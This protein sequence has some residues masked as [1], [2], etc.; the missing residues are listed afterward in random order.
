MNSPVS[1]LPPITFCVPFETESCIAF[2]TTGCC[3]LQYFSCGWVPIKRWVFILFVQCCIKR[4]WIFQLSFSA[5]W[6]V[7]CGKW[8]EIHCLSIQWVVNFHFLNWTCVI[9]MSSPLSCFL[10]ILFLTSAWC[11]S[12]CIVL[13]ITW[14][15]GPAFSVYV[16][17][18]WDSG[19]SHSFNPSS[20]HTV[21]SFCTSKYAVFWLGGYFSI[22]SDTFIVSIN[23]EILP[24]FVSPCLWVMFCSLFDP[25]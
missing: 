4:R 15:D 11:G 5:K 1:P 19:F 21:L 24:L 6:E 23:L 9:A 12:I 16:L 7:H 2:I 20:N 17:Y 25:W 18:K 14:S 13:Y 8:L 10:P 22:F 3:G